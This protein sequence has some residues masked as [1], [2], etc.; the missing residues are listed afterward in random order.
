MMRDLSQV[1]VYLGDIKGDN[2]LVK[3]TFIQNENKMEF[4]LKLTDP[5]IAL[6]TE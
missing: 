4:K 2:I 5:G 3:Q 6:I 1:G